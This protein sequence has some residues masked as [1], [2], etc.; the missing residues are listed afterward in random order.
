MKEKRRYWKL[1]E[2]ALACTLDNSLWKRLWAFHM[3]DYVMT[4]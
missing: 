1:K 2:E 3:T 4:E